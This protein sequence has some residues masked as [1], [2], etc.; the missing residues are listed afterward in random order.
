MPETELLAAL[1]PPK[2]SIAA[3]TALP[4][5]VPQSTARN[6]L[7]YRMDGARHIYRKFPDRIFTGKLPRM[8][9]AVGVVHIDIDAHGEVTAIHWARSPKNSP[10]VAIEIEQLVRAAAPYPAPVHLG[11]VSYTE[12]WLWDKSG[13]FQLD[14]LTQGQD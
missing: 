3:P 8:V 4:A 2:V 7:A 11:S 10:R 5:P 9:L 13:R 1:T 14:T 6:P 12:T